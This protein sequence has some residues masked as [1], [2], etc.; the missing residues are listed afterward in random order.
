MNWFI[1]MVV[2]WAVVMGFVV[3]GDSA[4]KREYNTCVVEMAKLNKD[5]KECKK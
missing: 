5:S 3:V 2:C 4:N 1:A